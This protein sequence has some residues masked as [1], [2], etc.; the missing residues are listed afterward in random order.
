MILFI[1]FRN[2]INKHTKNT[3]VIATDIMPQI[4]S[5]LP[6]ESR[7]SV[8]DSVA[9]FVVSPFKIISPFHF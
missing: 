1:F 3:T 4:V 8:N 7:I 9:L 2:V 5:K 6:M